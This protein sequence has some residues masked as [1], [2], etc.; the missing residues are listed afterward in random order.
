[1]E[2]ITRSAAVHPNPFR[3]AP[4]KR[5]EGGPTLLWATGRGELPGLPRRTSWR[6]YGAPRGAG[7]G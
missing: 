1:D 3:E 7:E 4:R 5:P 2:D 6:W